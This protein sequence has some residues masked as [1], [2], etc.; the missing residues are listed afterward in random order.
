MYFEAA[1]CQVQKSVK[2]LFAECK[3]NTQQSLLSVFLTQQRALRV[4]EI[5]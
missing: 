3:K 1:L 4:P 5:F 2:Q